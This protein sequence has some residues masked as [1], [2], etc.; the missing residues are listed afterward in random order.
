M[1]ER[2]VE[3]HQVYISIKQLCSWI[4]QYYFT[5]FSSIYLLFIGYLIIKN[6]KQFME[7]LGAFKPPK[8]LYW[9]MLDFVFRAVQINHSNTKFL[10]WSLQAHQTRKFYENQHSESYRTIWYLGFCETHI[11][12]NLK[13]LGWCGWY[14]IGFHR[15]LQWKGIKPH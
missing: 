10:H 7:S 5:S 14:L 2:N 3:N 4:R 6:W 12:V 15:L 13:F 9:T 11:Y 1:T 8:T